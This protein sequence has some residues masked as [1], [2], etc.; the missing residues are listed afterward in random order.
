MDRGQ[1]KNTRRMRRALRAPLLAVLLVLVS[2][3][4]AQGE[5]DRRE[6]AR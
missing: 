4:A 2:A 3:A 5:H 6:Y 1:P